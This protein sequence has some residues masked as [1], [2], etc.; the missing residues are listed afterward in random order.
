M[1]VVL[2]FY[3]RRP[4]LTSEEFS[5]YWRDVH[6]KL[7]V[8]SPD[9]RKYLRRYVQHHVKPNTLNPVAALGF[10]GFS[11]V[12]YDRREDRELLLATDYF[13]TVIVP[14]EANF[15]DMSQTRVSAYDEQV[16]QFP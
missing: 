9:I 11:E 6:G 2:G 5:A 16:V 14:D 13:K 3:K 10:D 12:W 4:D 15:L 1:H 7:L 8:A